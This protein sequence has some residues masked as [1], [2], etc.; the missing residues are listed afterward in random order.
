MHTFIRET[1]HTITYKNSWLERNITGLGLCLQKEAN[2]HLFHHA[3]E[4]CSNSANIRVYINDT[5]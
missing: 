4:T 3:L 5:V 1:L 2:P